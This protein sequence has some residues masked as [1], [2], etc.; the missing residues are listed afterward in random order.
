MQFQLARSSTKKA[1]RAL[2]RLEEQGVNAPAILGRFCNLLC[3]VF[4]VLAGVINQRDG[5]VESPFISKSYGK[6]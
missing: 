3:N 4:F 6:I 2:V 1:I 5:I